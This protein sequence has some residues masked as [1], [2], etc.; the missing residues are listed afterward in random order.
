MKKLIVIIGLPGSGKTTLAKQLNDGSYYLFDDMNKNFHLL[1]EANN[2]N[3]IIVTDPELCKYNQEF[4]IQKMNDFFGPHEIQFI[5]FENEP[6][7]ATLNCS[8]RIDKQVKKS[9]IY[10]LSKN[11]NPSEYLNIQPIYSKRGAIVNL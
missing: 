3:N 8:K 9:Y 7:L 11:Y 10:F 1:S 2:Y 5:A 4:I 6:E